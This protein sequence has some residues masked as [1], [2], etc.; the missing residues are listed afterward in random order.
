MIALKRATVVI[1]ALLAA[2]S[3]AAPA[4]DVP[5]ASSASPAVS[6]TATRSPAPSADGFAGSVAIT[7]PPGE[8]IIVIAGD[9]AVWGT[10]FKAAGRD[11]IRIDPQT[12]QVT[13]VVR[14]LPVAQIASVGA[15]GSI[16]SADYD[17]DTVTRFDATT[18]EELGT[19]AVGAAPIEPVVAY[20]SVWTLN[21]GGGTVSRIDPATGSVLATIE[22]G[23][24]SGAGP[25]AMADDGELL[26]VASPNNPEL[27]AIDPATNLVAREIA[28][29][30]PDCANYVAYA[31][32]R[33]WAAPC[34]IPGLVIY[35]VES[36]ERLG[37]VTR[38]V[39]NVPIFIDGVVWLA[40]PDA[41]TNRLLLGAV[42]LETL[43]ITQTLDL[44]PAEAVILQ[45]FDSLWIQ[46]GT[47][48]TRVPLTSLPP[49]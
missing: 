21:H 18:G 40:M 14:D 17:T 26:W 25:L 23:P 42:D 43:E 35:D 29:E 1:V 31:A 19:L 39:Q 36:G 16:W 15:G 46:S 28:L 37:A 13:T 7:V 32:G 22:V 4:T 27:V 41:A 6:P 30:D 34:G 47:T 20:G 44:A 45:A 49:A 11:I 38:A 9:D 3:G 33:L 10:V 48:W 24:G 2:C 8:P 5:G 12:N